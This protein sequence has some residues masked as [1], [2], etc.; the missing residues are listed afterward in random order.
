MLWVIVAIIVS[1]IAAFAVMNGVGTRKQGRRDE[2]TMWIAGALVGWLVIVFGWGATRMFHE[3]PAGHVGVVYQFGGI[4]G[5]VSD[6]FQVTAPWQSI[7]EASIQI[8]RATYELGHGNA[9]F[10]QESQ[11]VFASATINYEVLPKDIQRLYRDVG[12]GYEH[13]LIEQRVFQTIKEETV[14]FK[15]VDVAP[16]REVIRRRVRDRLTQQ[17]EPYSIL[18]VDFQL[19]NLD[20]DPEFKVAVRNKVIAKQKAQQALNEVQQAT[21]EA[22]KVLAAANGQARANLR[23]SQSLTPELVRYTLVQKLAPNI[24][25]IAIPSGSIFNATDLFGKTTQTR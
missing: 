10:S 2:G 25:V 24:Q 17:L 21:Y 15:A 8:Q 13:V 23:L 18:V 7:R 1:V 6:G 22:Q 5:Q 3:I 19:G 20:F 11:D 9:A 4:T 16:N 14:K 12:P